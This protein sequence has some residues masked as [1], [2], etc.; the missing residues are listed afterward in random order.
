MKF[1]MEATGSKAQE[2]EK[3]CANDLRMNNTVI[4]YKLYKFV[5]ISLLHTYFYHHQLELISAG[6]TSGCTELKFSLK[7]FSSLV[8]PMQTIYR[9]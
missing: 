5:Q 8:V 7:I 2:I 9:G 4:N 1:N 3:L 6:S